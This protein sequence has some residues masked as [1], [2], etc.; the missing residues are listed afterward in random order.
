MATLTVQDSSE[1]GTTPTF[2]GAAGGGDQFANNG[3]V[4]LWLKNTDGSTAT[5]TVTA[6]QASVSKPGFGSLTKS[7]AAVTVPATTGERVLGPFPID[8]FN[9]SSGNCLITYDSVTALTV[10]VIRLP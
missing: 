6:Q 4:L 5:V 8:A 9:N 3:K 1:S 10:A 2:N 7:N